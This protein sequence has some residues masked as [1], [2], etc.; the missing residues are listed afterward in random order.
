MADFGWA[1]VKGGLVTGASAPSGSIQF[2]D[3]SNQF[4][5]TSDLTI[6]Q[7]ATT[8]LALTGNLGV[9]GEISASTYYGDGSNLSGITTNPAGSDT[10]IQYND[11]GNWGASSNLTFDGST[12]NLTGTL[13]VSGAINANELNITV[14]NKDVVN[15]STTGSTKFG[16]TVDDIHQFTGSMY[17]GT[18]VSSSTYYGD[19]SNL[20]GLATTL[21]EVTDNGNSTTN[22]MTAS[23]MNLTSVTTGES[24]TQNRFLTLDSGNNIVLTSSSEGT[25]GAAEDGTYTDGLFTDFTS[26]TSV[27]TAVD[28]F[29]ELFKLLVPG[30]AP[31]VDRANYV[32]S[33]GYGLLLSVDGTSK[34]VDYVGVANTGSFS[35][36]LGI[37]SQYSASTS[38]EDFRIGVLAGTSDAN[39]T[40]TVNFHVNEET[41]GS[42]INYSNN[43]FGN[44]ES[45]S[46]KL[47]LND[48]M[49]HST[50]LF[51]LAGVGNPNSG[52]AT[53]LNVSGS[54]FINISTTASARDQIGTEFSLFQHRT[55][56]FIVSYQDQA[57]GWNVAR[58]EHEYGNVS[59]VTNHVQWFYDRDAQS[60]L[61]SVANPRMTVSGIGSKYLS[62][63]QYFTSA[64]T[65]YNAEILNV[66][67]YT[68]PTG[69]V[70]SFNETR[71]NTT[72]SI[73][74][75]EIGVGEDYN[76]IVEVTASSTN[77]TNP[78]L[79]TTFVRSLNLTHPIKND[80]ASTGSVTTGPTLIYNVTNPSSNL[81]EKF[82]D[83]T[84]RILSSSYGL[85]SDVSSSWDSTVHMTASGEAGYED[86]LLFF[87]STLRSPQLT[88]GYGS[89]LFGD[90]SAITEGPAGN[91]DYSGQVGVKSFYRKVQNTTGSPI[92]DMEITT[93]KIDTTFTTLIS[94]NQ[95]RLFVKIPE[96]TGWMDVSQNFSYGNVSDGDGALISG[97]SNDTDSG[98]NIHH[99][100]FGTA[101]L[102][103]GDYA[104]FKIEASS[105]WG[106][107]IS[108]MNFQLGASLASSAL[109]A[110]D[111]DFID[112]D[113]SGPQAN[114]SFG[115]SNIISGYTNV[116]ASS[117]PDVGELDL[118]SN[119]L[120]PS[121]GD[122]RGILTSFQ[123]LSGT[124]N[125][126]ISANGL[127]YPNFA[128]N[129]AM[130]GSLVLELNGVEIS[131]LELSSSMDA[132]SNVTSNTGLS[133]SAVSFSNTSDSIPD[134]FK[135]YR[136]GSWFASLA[137]GQR[138]G[139]NNARVLHRIGG[140]D[141]VFNFVQW[142]NDT[143]VD[144]FNLQSYVLVEQFNSDTF[145]NQ[146][147]VKY[148]A[149]NTSGSMSFTLSG[150][151]K[152]VYS[153]DN[154]AV[155]LVNV[156]NFTVDSITISGSGVVEKTD[157][158]TNSYTSLADLNNTANCQNQFAY[159]I[160][161]ASYSGGDSIPND[162]SLFTT[163]T[164]AYSGSAKHPTKSIGSNGS[165]ESNVFLY[166]S[167]T[168]NGSN[169]NTTERFGFEDYRIISGNYATQADLTSSVNS[170]DSSLSV[171]NASYPSHRTG[172]LTVNGFM[173]SPSKI[174]SAG[175]LSG[176]VKPT[177]NPDYSTLSISTREFYR[178][179]ENNSGLSS[180]TPTITLYGDAY[181]VAKSGA[182][183]TGTLGANKNINVEMKVSYD[184]NYTGLD[185]TSTAWGDCVKPYSA[186]TQPDVDGVGVY[187][188]GGSGLTQTVGSAGTS[189]QLQLQQKQIRAG[190][191]LVIKISAHK[192][193]TGY[194][195]RIDISY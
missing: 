155:S 49:I 73:A 81:V 58:V 47:Y 65:T 1:F 84:Y 31:A 194:L 192:D 54:G 195:T 45:G 35:D 29:N 12:M 167:G 117:L 165:Y 126:D 113:F 105:S 13:N 42:E 162:L 40:G 9:E 72:A 64:N 44:A 69:N 93:S 11:A 136:T 33:D 179:F 186:G 59:Y 27:G 62:G 95:A 161:S 100:T 71:L 21:Q 6:K 96:S 187:G 176:F 164:V 166:H 79:G 175:S 38:G 168:L 75:E 108:Q 86:G 51:A 32:S 22:A 122:Y 85:Q 153:P 142:V 141:K 17:V 116:T 8:E 171:D 139:W 30:P 102:A 110:P 53:S 173:F 132:L 74:L 78:M 156:S 46:L 143:N 36:S 159:A 134:Y 177:G 43:A 48:V 160:V 152:N 70:L 28:R 158:S 144:A 25:I 20:T 77:S 181:L 56:D 37:N 23:N 10:Q 76:K 50:T 128:F 125:S 87:N 16:D 103:S 106:G 41:K 174:G 140:V 14:T 97:A 172:L 118:D 121:S 109:E 5:G 137:A 112:G 147:G 83:E 4:A 34:P 89:I 119:D 98:D 2:N 111:M 57:K 107:Y 90:F 80:L 154:D 148:F 92:Y 91:P 101:S 191:F 124:L 68:Y 184:P 182:F 138:L 115:A 149:G 129:D 188:G 52:S 127:N 55:A 66:Y 150:V 133:V 67:K 82:D 157:N 63:V 18:S 180:V 183:Y 104:L 61:M 120:F 123:N 151:Y 99:I 131:T 3:G 185:D 146:S 189:F 19:G 94:N 15:I 26:D 170:W 39:V 190:Q 135:P 24:P 145:Y 7:G 60:S 130:T 169:A 193:W 88:S 114:L 163:R 178:L